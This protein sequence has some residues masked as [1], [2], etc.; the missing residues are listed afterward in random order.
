[1]A[2]RHAIFCLVAVVALA[3]TSN[4]ASAQAANGTLQFTEK[5]LSSRIG[6]NMMHISD[7]MK[8]AMSGSLKQTPTQQPQKVIQTHDSYYNIYH[9][10]RSQITV[11]ATPALAFHVAAHVHCAA[12]LQV[13]LTPQQQLHQ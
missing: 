3:H 7:N 6:Y 8:K 11:P 4:L 13:H 12:A 9:D 1:M 2:R 5:W 10:A